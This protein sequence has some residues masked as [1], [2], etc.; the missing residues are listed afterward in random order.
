MHL[1]G[2]VA[3]FAVAVALVVL[4]W[5]RALGGATSY[6]VVSGVSM[7]PTYATG[8]L[9]VARR[10]AVYGVGDVIAFRTAEGD[11][12]HRIIGGD[13]EA[14]FRTQGDNVD[15]PDPYLPRPEDIRG[16]AVAS[17]PAVGAWGMRLVQ[18]IP[19][20]LL[21]AGAI[22]L[23]IG[24]DR[25]RRRRR[26][27]RTSSAE[28]V[29][30]RPSGSIVSS[31]VTSHPSI[32]AAAACLV[33]AVVV[34]PSAVLAWRTPTTVEVPAADAADRHELD[35]TVT[36]IAA[37]DSSLYPRGRSEPIVA[38][39]ESPTGA[40][41]D[42][43]PTLLRAQVER[44]EVA[45]R[46]VAAASDVGGEARVDVRMR[47]GRGFELPLQGVPTTTFEGTF[48]QAVVVDLAA[49]E[50]RLEQY[51]ADAG[52]GSDSVVVEVEPVVTTDDGAVVED[53]PVV[54][55]P[56][57]ELIEVTGTLRTVTTPDGA[58]TTRTPDAAL[59]GVPMPV[60]V[61][62]TLA[63]A[64]VV[65]LLAAALVLVRRAARDRPDLRI[66]LL[67]GSLLVEIERDANVGGEVV[68]VSSFAE[69][70]RLARRDHRS[71]LHQ[72]RADDT[73]RYLVPD[74]E[75]TYE[76]VVDLAGERVAGP[77]P[78][79]PDDATTAG[80]AAVPSGS[81]PRRVARARAVGTSAAGVTG[82]DPVLDRLPTAPVDLPSGRVVVVEDFAELT[83]IWMRDNAAPGRLERRRL[84]DGRVRYAVVRNGREFVYEAPRD[85]DA[86]ARSAGD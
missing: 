32:R 72:H 78:D 40:P 68:R 83:R 9:V 37:E 41:A 81:A 55:S 14:G 13:A 61:V 63:T 76:Y 57:S 30:P 64:I 52:L 2:R 27:G 65:A 25:S 60:P 21:V 31:T 74:A 70:A 5:P 10:A 38:D 53:Q 23:G 20:P 49:V 67:H 26:P 56:T 36:G 62:R 45:V 24:G 48:D 15:R 22:L 17:L 3:V 6:V 77:G 86:V 73:H 71:I 43:A 12:I 34:L 33:A 54:L 42:D 18:T 47:T 80:G 4:A 28:P 84:T 75:L 29:H 11:V 35:V 46:H 50:Q 51:L 82:E 16:R 8:D 59:V 58:T 66:G 39:P 85:E 44:V 7:E 19:A 79:V 1:T 69:L